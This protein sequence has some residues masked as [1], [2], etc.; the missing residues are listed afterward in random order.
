MSTPSRILT[1]LVLVSSAFVIQPAS[2][3]LGQ[4]VEWRS[5][6]NTARRE[7]AS[8]N[9]PLVIDFG[10]ENCF[11]C[12]K[13]DA[14]TFKDPTV[15]SLMNEKFIPLK[16]DAEREAPLTSALHIESYPT[17]VFATAE[18]KILEMH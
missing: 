11:W 5:D 17:L 15:I 3:A 16:V 7:A 13:L 14:I 1:A 8:K 6:Y 10:T 9:R 12:K 4:E 18:G 2:S